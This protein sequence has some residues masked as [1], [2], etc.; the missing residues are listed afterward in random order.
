LSMPDNFSFHSFLSP[1]GIIPQI[2]LFW[3]RLL[4]NG[5]EKR[6]EMIGKLN[7]K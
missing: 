6:E 4:F 5:T 2:L 7:Y 3:D 1:F